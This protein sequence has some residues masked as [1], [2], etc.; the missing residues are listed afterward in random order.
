MWGFGVPG[1]DLVVWGW[2]RVGISQMS[3]KTIIL[4]V[5]FDPPKISLSFCQF[6]LTTKNTTYHFADT[7]FCRFE[8]SPA[9]PIILAKHHFCKLFF[10]FFRVSNLS[11]WRVI[12]LADK[13][14]RVELYK[15]SENNR[16]TLRP[17]HLCKNIDNFLVGH[18]SGLIKM[19][20]S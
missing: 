1:V 16:L 5:Y 17:E 18:V 13:Y 7:S 3:T 4:P 10:W 8:K 9:A 20:I 6:S 14:C 12:I 19:L 2:E 15:V 11:F